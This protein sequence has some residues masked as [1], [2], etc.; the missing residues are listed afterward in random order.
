MGGGHCHR[1]D[2]ASGI[3]PAPQHFVLYTIA[4]ELAHLV[5]GNGSG[6]PHGEVAC[7]VWIISRLPVELLDQRLYYLLARRHSRL[8]W[9][10]NKAAVREF[11]LR[12]IELRKP[13]R[14]YIVWLY[15]QL[16][17]LRL[18]PIVFCCR[19]YSSSCRPLMFFKKTRSSE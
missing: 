5:Q 6:I 16:K 4:H 9:K 17:R 1:L 3:S 15:S 12:D 8:D 10:K 18:W 2:V 14:T 11:C 13:Q 19:G 7:D